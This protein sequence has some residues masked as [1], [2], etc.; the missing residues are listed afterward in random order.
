M[1]EPT[2]DTTGDTAAAPPVPSPA[3]AAPAAVEA[4]GESESVPL[5]APGFRRENVNTPLREGRGGGGGGGGMAELMRS[6]ERASALAAIVSGSGVGF[7]PI[8]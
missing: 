5:E 6:D 3:S 8:V 2:G 1:S 7:G 4:F